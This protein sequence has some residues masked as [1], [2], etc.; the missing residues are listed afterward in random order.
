[1]VDDAGGGFADFMVAGIGILRAAA[2]GEGRKSQ[3][4]G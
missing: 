1:M 2:G 4:G 3:K